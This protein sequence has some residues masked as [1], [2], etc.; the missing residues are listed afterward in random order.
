[1]D[2][3]TPTST[4]DTDAGAALKPVRR[5]EVLKGTTG[6][7]RT[8]TLEEKLALVAEMERS[9]NIAAF[10]RERDVSTS[11]LYTWR[12]ELRYAVEARQLPPHPDPMFVPVLEKAPAP[13]C[14]SADGMVE[15]EIAG[16]LV[17][18]GQAVRTD[19]AVAVIHALRGAKAEDRP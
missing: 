5:L 12:R 4:L 14:T 9:G 17:R 1:M 16:A 7:R 19:L 3:A 10:S 2:D 15:I 6:R 18:I 8:W 13:A 11:L